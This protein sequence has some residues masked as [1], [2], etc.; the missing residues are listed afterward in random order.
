MKGAGLLPFVRLFPE[1]AMA[2][3][4]VFMVRDHPTLPDDD[5]G[6]METF[7]AD[8]TCH[9]R[10]VML[11]VAARRQG[12]FLASVSYAFDRDDPHAGPFLDPLNP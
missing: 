3:T 11:N 4:R 10:R 5:Y 8:T 7:C 1:L 2:E 9:C 12:V 6:L